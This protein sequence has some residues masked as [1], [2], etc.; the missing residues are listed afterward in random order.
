MA[1]DISHMLRQLRTFFVMC[2]SGF[3]NLTHIVV[4]HKEKIYS[5]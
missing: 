4:N 2:V 5:G 3:I 1:F